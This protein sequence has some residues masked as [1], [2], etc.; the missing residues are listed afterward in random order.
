MTMYMYFVIMFVCYVVGFHVLT[1]VQTLFSKL[2]HL[3][4][5]YKDVTELIVS[6]EKGGNK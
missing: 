6:V 2:R 3:K 1:Q 4:Y 5:K